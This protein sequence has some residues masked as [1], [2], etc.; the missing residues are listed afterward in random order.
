VRPLV[1]KVD[2]DV[3]ACRLSDVGDSWR[4]REEGYACRLLELEM[5]ED[6]DACRLS[7]VGDSW[8]TREEG[9]S[10]RLL[11]M[12]LEEDVEAR[13]LSDVG[14]CWRA[15]EEVCPCRLLEIELEGAGAAVRRKLSVRGTAMCALNV[16]GSRACTCLDHSSWSRSSAESLIGVIEWEEPVWDCR[17]CI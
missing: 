13:R 9:Y 15:R 10:C 7:D 4:A 12:E 3:D 16:G 8:R 14:E 6:V 11:E 5:G 2:E 17:C 1:L